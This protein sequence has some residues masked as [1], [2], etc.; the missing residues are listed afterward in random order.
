MDYLVHGICHDGGYRATRRYN[1]QHLSLSNVE[2]FSRGM[3]VP[4]TPIDGHEIPELRY[5][6]DPV[7]DPL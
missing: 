6:K 7:K 5:S 4:R 3:P 1:I 2:S